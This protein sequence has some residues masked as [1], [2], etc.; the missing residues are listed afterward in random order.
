[1]AS[2]LKAF[3]LALL[4]ACP[5]LA[6]VADDN[7]MADHVLGKVDAPV[8]VDEFVSLTCSHCAEFYTT[9]LPI[10]EKKYVDTGKVKFVMHDFPL[11]GISL[12]SAA[13]A[14]C[15]PDDEYFPFVKTLYSNQLT[16][17]FSGG[18]PEANMI[19]YATLGG[20][21]AEKAKACAN[22][23]KMQ[24]AIIAAR[25]SAAAKYHVD[26]TP[27]FVLNDGAQ[28]IQGAQAA[29]VFSAAFDHLL[30]AKK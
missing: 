29:D 12:K 19:R 28:V 6:A 23:T 9:V 16:W 27:T 10:L 8:K 4:M 26:A 25:E 21:T 22:D 20:L 1:M 14:R 5:A 11:D 3:V 2:V 15:M 13:V 30:A 7:R 17:A 18:D 24:D